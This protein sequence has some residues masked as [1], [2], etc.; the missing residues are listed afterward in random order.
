MED[1]APDAGT[2]VLPDGTA[3]NYRPICRADREALQR[4]HGRHSALSIYLRFFH[5]QRTLSESQASY[6]TDV[7][8]VDRFALVALDPSEPSEIIAVARFDREPGAARAEYAAIV[9]GVYQR[10]GLGRQLTRCLIDSAKRQGVTM[11]RAFVLP[12]NLPMIKLLRHLNFP[13]VVQF[14]DGV[15]LIDVDLCGD[16]H[17]ATGLRPNPVR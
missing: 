11:F 10:R 6:F 9:A 14:E 2:I 15:E 7:D 13:E 8:G 3:I 4:F 17:S 1:S 5:A 16:D 12:E